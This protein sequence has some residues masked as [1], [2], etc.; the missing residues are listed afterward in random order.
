[1]KLNSYKEYAPLPSF[2]TIKQSNI[3]GLGLFTTE[4]IAKGTDLGQSHYLCKDGFIR[5]PLGGFVNHS[6]N[7][8]LKLVRKKGTRFFHAV[9]IKVVQAGSELTGEYL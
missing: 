9:T 2:L 6:D 4:D 3:H 5:L 1:M 8:N 7:P